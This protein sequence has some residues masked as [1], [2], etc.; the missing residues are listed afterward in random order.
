MGRIAAPPI[1]APFPRPHAVVSPLRRSNRND[2][3]G[4]DG[5]V[6]R[7]AIAAIWHRLGMTFHSSQAW[8]PLEPFSAFGRCRVWVAGI[9]GLALLE[10]MHS[11][12][13]HHF[14]LSRRQRPITGQDERA[15]HGTASSVATAGRADRVFLDLA[16][17]AYD[18]P[19]AGL[20]LGAYLSSVAAAFRT[21]SISCCRE[22]SSA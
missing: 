20:G 6:E 4:R 16:Q 18:R 21:V 5:L 1:L 8:T 22:C 19:H 11:R 15:A 12:P 10:W 13:E 2:S 7:A 9:L 14:L 17:A 3:A